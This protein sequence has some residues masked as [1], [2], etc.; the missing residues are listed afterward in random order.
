MG[1]L[2]N[3]EQ[4]ISNTYNKI[5]ETICQNL[6][7]DDILGSYSATGIETESIAF[8]TEMQIAIDNAGNAPAKR[9]QQHVGRE[10]YRLDCS[11]LCKYDAIGWLRKVSQLS[12]SPKPILVI[13]NITEIPQEDEVHDNPKYVENLLVLS[14]KNPA[15]Q[16]TDNRPGQN[17]EQ[18]SI[19]PHDYTVFLT[20]KPEDKEKLNN[21]WCASDGLAWIG[22]FA[23]YK[24]KFTDDYKQT[25]LSE[26]QKLCV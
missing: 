20:W 19:N 3:D 25:D 21:V 16:F 14:W 2:D 4:V 10:I 5:K 8:V 6:F 12:L 23:D 11:K 17:N 9:M 1:L 18:F 15:N 7:W 22:N 13:E 26:L 24:Q